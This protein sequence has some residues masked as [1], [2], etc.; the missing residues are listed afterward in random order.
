MMT[1][2]EFQRILG[3][4]ELPAGLVV[5]WN[6][7]PTTAYLQIKD[8]ALPPAFNTGRKWR[9]SAHM[10]RSEVVQTAFAALM[11]WVEHEAREAFRYKGQ[12]VFG[13]HLDVE[14]LHNV[15]ANGAHDYRDPVPV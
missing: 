12:A 4:I 6:W 10:T 1:V 9:I 15:A 13:P 2:D 11:A 5:K 14:V 8:P 3:D 7:T